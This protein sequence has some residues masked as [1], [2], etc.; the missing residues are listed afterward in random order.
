MNALGVCA[1]VCVC[2][3]VCLHGWICVW[4]SLS[5]ATEGHG[6]GKWIYTQEVISILNFMSSSTVGF[7]L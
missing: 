1:S 2:V 5:F 3:G 6:H 4:G 7:G